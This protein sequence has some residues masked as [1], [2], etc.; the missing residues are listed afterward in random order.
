[1]GSTAE[2]HILYS[3][4]IL[5]NVQYAEN[6]IKYSAS[7]GNGIE[8][9]R[10]SFRP[11]R[12]TINGKDTRSDNLLIPGSYL[13]RKLGNGDYALTIKHSEPCEILISGL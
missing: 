9:L 2:D 7:S 5:R 3:E 4:G 6:Q 1:M 10:L 13:L 8:Y 12:V 11:A